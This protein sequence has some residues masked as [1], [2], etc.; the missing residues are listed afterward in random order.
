MAQRGIEGLEEEIK[1]R[2][3]SL[4]P[5]AVSKEKMDECVN[6]IK[7]N[8]IDTMLILSASTLRDEFGFGKDRLARFIER[9]NFK[10]EC[11]VDGCCTWD[12]QMTTLAEECGI[13]LSIRHN[14]KNVRV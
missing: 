14:N 9:F 1:Y 11:L 10:A 4:V 7:M 2:N 8:T 3:I 13:K 6:N 5:I 12:D